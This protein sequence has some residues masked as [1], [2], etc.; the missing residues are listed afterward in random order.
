MHFKYEAPVHRRPEDMSNS[1]FFP[2]VQLQYDP[3]ALTRVTINRQVRSDKRNFLC[4]RE[5]GEYA[6]VG[7]CI[8]GIY[9]RQTESQLGMRFE[10]EMGLDELADG[11][12]AVVGSAHFN[13]FA[14]VRQRS[15]AP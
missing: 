15:Q 10:R 8:R 7:A 9:K 11:F 4:L 14:K 3:R 2:F 5:I 13:L 12:H 6:Q 1:I